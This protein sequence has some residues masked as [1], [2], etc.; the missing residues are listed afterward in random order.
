MHLS[1]NE[2]S[3]FWDS[4]SSHLISRDPVTW[5]DITFGPKKHFIGVDIYTYR[6]A[7]EGPLSIFVNETG[8]IKPIYLPDP[9]SEFIQ[10]LFNQQVDVI[11]FR[12]FQEYTYEFLL[13]YRR[14]CEA[15]LFLTWWLIL[16][17][18]QEPF[19][20]FR[21]GCD[22]YLNLITGALPNI[23]GIDYCPSLMLIFLRWITKKLHQLVL[24]MPF[25][26]SEGE[27]YTPAQ[28]KEGILN[29]PNL[30]EYLLEFG[31]DVRIFR[32]F[33]SLLTKYPIPDGLR[34]T[35]W[36][37]GYT[38]EL[39]YKFNDLGVKLL[40]DKQF[41]KLAREMDLISSHISFENFSSQLLAFKL[42]CL[43]FLDFIHH[44]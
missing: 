33:P 24:T 10:C 1:I 42:H 32:N 30:Q 2:L 43:P 39:I 16:N 3:S 36:K 17:P 37:M 5:W 28:I 21:I 34:Q 23:I 7:Y 14:C 9:V 38:K 25:L 18:Y 35:W 19:N 12:E 22:S 8:R 31:N 15:R 20:T 4:V 11:K 6:D 41:D 27:L 44:F 13:F 26:P 29:S 40:P